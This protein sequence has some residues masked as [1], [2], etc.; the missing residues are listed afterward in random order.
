MPN[1]NSIFVKNTGTG[2]F[3]TVD[4]PVSFSYFSKIGVTENFSDKVMV[5]E[6]GGNYPYHY[7]SDG[8][9]TLEE[10]RAYLKYCEAKRQN[11]YRYDY[12]ILDQLRQTCDF[13]LRNRS[14]GVSSLY[15][16]SVETTISKMKQTWS[17]LPGDEKPDWLSWEDILRYEGLMLQVE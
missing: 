13:F 17:R 11:L 9:M 15:G 1:E 3:M 5:R 6:Y 10:F 8:Y 12:M 4:L 14:R 2:Q 7:G 16:G